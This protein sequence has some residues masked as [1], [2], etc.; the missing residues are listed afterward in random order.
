MLLLFPVGD[1][2]DV[3][4][5]LVALS[6]NIPPKT[7]TQSECLEDELDL[8]MELENIGA[9][10]SIKPKQVKVCIMADLE[11]WSFIILL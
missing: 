6:E 2:K 5:P 7:K 3:T 10:V 8:D 11:T 4:V 1:K 9:L